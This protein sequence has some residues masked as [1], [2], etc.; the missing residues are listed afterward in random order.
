MDRIAFLPGSQKMKL[1]S[2]RWL[3]LL[4]TA[5]LLLTACTTQE[6][7]YRI[8]PTKTTITTENMDS[9]P[10]FQFKVYAGPIYSDEQ[11]ARM[12][13]SQR[14]RAGLL[15]PEYE[16]LSQKGNDGYYIDGRF[17]PIWRNIK[18]YSAEGLASWYGPG[19]H[20]R[21]T[22]NGEIYD[23]YGISAAHKSL[24]IPCFIHVTNLENG[25]TLIVRVNDRGPYVGDRILDLSY[26][27]ASRLGLVA[28]G[29][30]KVKIDLIQPNS[31]LLASYKP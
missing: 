11:Y 12:S 4:L 2:L 9:G 27:A 1:G 14:R 15:S 21:K 8:R 20:G 7:S 3:V 30:A 22:A 19:F 28:D 10:A 23:Q 17:Y 6:V 18:Q 25:R 16:P 5:N 26:G 31:P 13:P 29:V 24:P